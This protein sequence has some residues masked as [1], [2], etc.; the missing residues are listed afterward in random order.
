MFFVIYYCSKQFEKWKHDFKIREGCL[1]L[2]LAFYAEIYSLRL[3]RN[4]QYD[5]YENNFTW[6]YAG[7]KF[8]YGDTMAPCPAVTEKS[9]IT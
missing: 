8:R 1:N 3:F 2:L 9:I 5:I 6:T 7:L 4:L